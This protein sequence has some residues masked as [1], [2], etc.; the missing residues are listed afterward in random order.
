MKW[1]A[2]GQQAD[3]GIQLVVLQVFEN[4][5][6]KGH[7]DHLGELLEVFDHEPSEVERDLLLARMDVP[8]IQE[9][10]F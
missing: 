3:L 8:V 5:R 6:P 10:P 2:Y 1:V 9:E 7:V 4:T